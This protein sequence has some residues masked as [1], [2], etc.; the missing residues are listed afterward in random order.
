[1]YG[2]ILR[3]KFKKKAKKEDEEDKEQP[4]RL[5]H[6]T[7]DLHQSARVI[8]FTLFSYYIAETRGLHITEQ[9]TTMCEQLSLICSENMTGEKMPSD[10]NWR[11]SIIVAL[12]FLVA[13][14]TIER[15]NI[16]IRQESIVVTSLWRFFNNVLATIPNL[17]EMISRENGEDV[18]MIDAS[19]VQSQIVGEQLMF[20]QSEI[21]IVS[22]IDFQLTS[23]RDQSVGEK[24]MQRYFDSRKNYSSQERVVN[25]ISDDK[26][27]QVFIE[28]TVDVHKRGKVLSEAIYGKDAPFQAIDDE[29]NHACDYVF[30]SLILNQNYIKIDYEQQSVKMQQVMELVTKQMKKTIVQQ[31]ESY[32]G[33]FNL[34]GMINQKL[35]KIDD[36]MDVIFFVQYMY[37]GNEKAVD[38]IRRVQEQYFKFVH[39]RRSI[40]QF[41]EVCSLIFQKP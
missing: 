34:G 4:D 9:F 10:C 12:K 7:L 40:T 28:T 41:L 16:P 31:Q 11:R 33:I 36:V 17:D 26:L 6:Y 15:D 8:A 3:N 23:F 13:P 19:A 18:P 30:K 2:M 39:N 1:M 24:L 37:F 22:P 25:D 32:C 35:I 29:G 20:G 21:P 27:E 14:I 38:A 5:C